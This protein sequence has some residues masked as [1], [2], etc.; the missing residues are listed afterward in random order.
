MTAAPVW[1][2]L[3]PAAVTCTI[4]TR[5]HTAQAVLIFQMFLSK[6]LKTRALAAMTIKV[7]NQRLMTVPHVTSLRYILLRSHKLTANL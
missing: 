7:I 5:A 2:V 1:S 3:S 4:N 6:V